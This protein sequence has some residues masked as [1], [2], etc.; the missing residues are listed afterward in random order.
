[1]QLLKHY[2]A[3]VGINSS[4]GDDAHGAFLTIQHPKAVALASALAAQGVECD[5]RGSWLR[6]CPD[7]LTR[8]EELRTAARTLAAIKV[9]SLH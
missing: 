5:A 7:C 1:L 3:D 2:L 4:G 6:L 9:D 8:D